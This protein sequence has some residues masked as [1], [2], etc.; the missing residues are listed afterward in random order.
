MLVAATLVADGQLVGR[1]SGAA[2]ELGSQCAAVEAC[3]VVV[4]ELD[5]IVHQHAVVRRALAD[6]QRGQDIGQEQAGGCVRVLDTYFNVGHGRHAAV[7]VGQCDAD[8]ARSGAGGRCAVLI[9]EVLDQRLYRFGGGIGVEAEDQFVDARAATVQRGDGGAAILHVAAREADLPAAVAFVAHTQCLACSRTVQQLHDQSATIEIG[10]IDIGHLDVAIEQL[11]VA[12][13]AAVGDVVGEDDGW[14]QVGNDGGGRAARQ[15]DG[16]AEQL[17]FDLV[18]TVAAG[19]VVVVG[20]NH[21]V[22]A[23]AEIGD[24]R[25]VLSGVACRRQLALGVEWRA[26]ARVL[27]NEHIVGSAAA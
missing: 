2:D 9:G 5:S 11:G 20:I 6:P 15:I 16:T 22:V 17:L 25:H 3:G 12:R 14:L 23:V 13:I 24:G 19:G 4:V 10:R 21:D 27:A 1:A 26:G 18:G 8:V 7:T